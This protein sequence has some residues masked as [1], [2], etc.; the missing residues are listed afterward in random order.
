MN[1]TG[2]G[3]P[4]RFR[5][6]NVAMNAYLSTDISHLLTMALFKFLLTTSKSYRNLLDLS[7]FN[8]SKISGL[9]KDEIVAWQ[10]PL[11]EFIRQNKS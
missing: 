1:G 8:C 5:M 6:S 7:R 10:E 11:E 2:R 4:A 9:L 3:G